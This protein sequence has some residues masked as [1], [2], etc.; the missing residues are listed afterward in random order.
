MKDPTRFCL[1]FAFLIIFLSHQTFPQTH[2]QKIQIKFRGI[3]L[4]LFCLIFIGQINI[5]AQE[6]TGKIEGR[7]KDTNGITVSNVLI[8]VSSADLQGIQSAQT[9]NDGFFSLV[10]LP[11]GF[12]TANIKHIAYR[13]ITIDSI[14]VSVLPPS[15]AADSTA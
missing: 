5:L 12:Y 4:I 3:L 11:P 6:V 1:L 14:Q 8:S 10:L 15:G 13:S 7:I 2:I 9:D